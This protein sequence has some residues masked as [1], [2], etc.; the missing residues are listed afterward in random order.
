[1]HRDRCFCDLIPRIQTKSKLSLVIH[2]KELK[3][4]TNT[5]SLAVKALENSRLYV[6]GRMGET[7]SL[8]GLE[9]PDYRTVLLYPSADAVELT[10]AFVAES[11][12][13]IHLVVPDG[14]W[15][16]ASKVHYRQHELKHIQRV[17][18]QNIDTGAKHLRAEHTDYGM[19]T[20]QAIA[21][22]FGVIEG[23]DAKETLLK[24]YE[25]KLE[26]TLQGRKNQAT[27]QRSSH[28][29]T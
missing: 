10:P 9:T 12:L 21:H 6:R 3:R 26:R 16:Q 18:I 4:A 27:Q 8:A 28:E 11:D 14:N 13:P 22:A 29:S 17:M 19:A 20:L 5:G 1:M 24:L 7:L 15:R 25:L 23:A 2:A